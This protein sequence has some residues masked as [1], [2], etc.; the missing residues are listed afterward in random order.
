MK[1]TN[2]HIF[3][4]PELNVWNSHSQAMNTDGAAANS[5]STY[6]YMFIHLYNVL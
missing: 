4:Y 2:S 5:R 1:L 3:P 6:M